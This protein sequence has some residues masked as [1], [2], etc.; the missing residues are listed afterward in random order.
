MQIKNNYQIEWEVRLPNGAVSIQ[1]K[2]YLMEI[3]EL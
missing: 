1:E 3:W 2:V